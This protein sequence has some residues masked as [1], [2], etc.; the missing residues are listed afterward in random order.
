MIKAIFKKK[1]YNLTY[2]GTFL[3]DMQKRKD[4]TDDR[5]AILP[6]LDKKNARRG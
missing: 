5:Q 3:Y 4:D 6:G 2:F 1:Y